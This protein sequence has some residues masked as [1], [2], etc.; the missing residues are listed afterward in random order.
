MPLTELGVTDR[1]APDRVSVDLR[2]GPFE[3]NLQ[4]RSA[5]EVFRFSVEDGVAELSE[6]DCERSSERTRCWLRAVLRYVDI[7]EQWD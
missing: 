7:E 6:R 1:F 4:I 3:V 5:V 2:R